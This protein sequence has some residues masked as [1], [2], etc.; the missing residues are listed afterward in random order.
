VYLDL[1]SHRPSRRRLAA[2]RLWRE[3]VLRRWKRRKP[4]VLAVLAAVVL[5]LGVVGFHMTPS[6]GKGS[7]P[8]S[9]LESFYRAPQLF[10][11]GGGDVANPSTYLQVARFL[12]PFV[13]GYAAL[14]AIFA[15]YREEL[16]R[17]VVRHWRRHVVVAG[18]GPAGSRLAKAFAEEGWPVVAIERD[19]TN[20]EVIACREQ[21]VRVL[22]G[23]ATEPSVLR[24]AGLDN[25]VLLAS[26]C[27][28]DRANIDVTA[29]A[30]AVC[31][32]PRAQ[33]LT[34]VAGFDDFDLWHAMKAPALVD[35]DSA[36]FRLELVNLWALAAERLL[37]TY[38]PFHSKHP[39]SPHVVV[40]SDEGLAG[41]LVIAVLRRWVRTERRDG[42]TLRLSL[43]GTSPAAV[44]DLVRR[45]PELEEISSCA[46]EVWD[47]AR[48][49]AP[50]ERADRAGPAGTTVYVALA[51]ET[52][53]LTT[54]LNIRDHLERGERTSLVVVVEDEGAGVAHA[55]RRG[56]VAMEGVHAFGWLSS[57]LRPAALLEGM[58]TE[59]I[60]RFAHQLHCE[61]ERA[62]GVT[63]AEDPSLV[64]W[65]FLPRALRE[66]NRAWADG[67]AAKLATVRCAVAPAPLVLP[68]NPG[69]VFEEE[70]VQRLAPLEHD[71]WSADMK[72]MGYRPGPRDAAHRP[73]ID[74]P[75]EALPEENKEKDREHVRMIPF[76]LAR[77]GFRVRRL[78]EPEPP[79]AEVL[80]VAAATT[81]T[82]K[83]ATSM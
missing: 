40:V 15:M 22:F 9:L 6:A 75:F 62:R 20:V 44:L 47:E 68:E 52:A 43:A 70:E 66:S 80:Q 39:G 31:A 58:S 71:R 35:R 12:A 60:A 79:S 41:S 81:S 26:F 74:V 34:A 10:G 28:D 55:V 69:F 25:A 42:D 3:H 46:I 11:L 1:L 29:A 65:E 56:G 45:N 37:D 30:R 53:A 38:P 57:A 83:R 64:A 76:V 27:G 59:V 54:A 18:L 5:T 78:S 4:A 82:T 33:V 77:A 49:L 19:A 23:D 32:H 51:S 63:E 8:Y 16:N 14:G 72:R 67:I 7:R 36:A 13:L 48:L 24:Q 61:H 17:F 73:Y 21:G 2:K 50:W